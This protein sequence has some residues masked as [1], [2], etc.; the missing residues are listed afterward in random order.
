MIRHDEPSIPTG[1]QA[2]G[3]ISAGKSVLFL[4]SPRT[5]VDHYKRP[6]TYNFNLPMVDAISENII[7]KPTGNS[8]NQTLALPDMST[9]IVPASDGISM[10]TSEYSDYWSFVLIIDDSPEVGS[11]FANN[12]TNRHILMGI[13]GAEPIGAV[14]LASA[15][16][17]SY[18]N[19]DCQLIVTR[20]L[21][22]NKYSTA[23]AVGMSDRV[24]TIADTNIAE[25]SPSV[26]TGNR[27]NHDN[28]YYSLS[29]EK[30]HTAVSMDDSEVISTIDHADSLNVTNSLKLSSTL[31]SPKK[32]MKEILTNIETGVTNSQFTDQIGE[33]GDGVDAI[34]T[35]PENFEMY[36]HGAFSEHNPL[37]NVGYSS[38]MEMDGLL[39]SEFLTIGMVQSHYRPNIIPIKTPVDTPASII[40]QHYTSVSNIFS[41]LICSC[42]PTYLNAVGLS[43]IAFMHNTANEATQ[44]NHIDSMVGSTQQELHYKW[45]ALQHLLKTEL[46]PILLNNGGH[47]DISISCSINSTTN[48]IL[49]FLDDTPLA[50]GEVYEENAILGGI[51]SPLVGTKEHMIN[52]S[53]QLNNLIRNISTNVHHTAGGY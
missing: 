11:M 33:F 10:N 49:N 26:W 2:V 17:G 8:V 1:S 24:K 6:L 20:K 14:G 47:F 48:V 16:P 35:G 29:P 53:H 31:E 15:T 9:A 43:A 22:L 7:N 51:V 23:S 40:P 21:M 50:P 12:L 4:F 30:A 25:F 28:Q 52:N 41:S 39:G 32:H 3:T 13:C 44:I 5:I 46:Y 34:S 27:Q 18:V 42:M 45:G 19:P 38:N 37:S 36:V